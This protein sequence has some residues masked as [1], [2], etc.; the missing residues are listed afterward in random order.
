[1]SIAPVLAL[2]FRATEFLFYHLLISAVD[3]VSRLPRDG[4][5]PEAMRLYRENIALKA[6]LDALRLCLRLQDKK[7]G[8]KR[9]PLG[10]RAAQVFAWLLTRRNDVFRHYYLS[11]SLRTI[12]RWA[13]RFRSPWHRP[14]AG[15]RPPTDTKLV[16]LVLTLKR[17]NPLWGEKRIRDELRRM[18]IKLARATIGKILR[19][20]GFR[21]I[22]NSPRPDIFDR[23]RAGAKDALWAL[24][25]FA[26]KTAK[27]VWVQALLVMDIYTRELL[28]L[29]VHDGWD[30]DSRWTARVFNE[31]L[32]RTKRKPIGVVH[33]HGTHFL[34]QF[35][36]QMRVLDIDEELTA[37]QFP[38]LNCYAEAAIGSLRRELLRHIRV[39]DA[40]ELQFFL[41]EFRRYMNDER[42]HQ[43][44]EGRTP[45]ERSTDA[46][47]AE[48]IDLAAVRARRLVRREYAHGLLNGY[49]LLGVADGDVAA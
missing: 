11:A 20:H 33:D 12:E 5:M 24:D 21:P 46:P 6:Q 43:G 31:M 7:K 29:R 48:V 28:E 32:G 34:G 16:E 49:D 42:A 36:R 3:R 1:V 38:A 13:T 14:R 35:R 15:G 8:K 19:E 37:V 22:P 44:I 26:V 40:A 10:V 27:G 2:A 9:V 25:F 17:E 23:F 39:A 47:E 4:V 45:V 30:V 18:G 41:D